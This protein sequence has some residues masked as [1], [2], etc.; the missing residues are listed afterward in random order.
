MKYNRIIQGDCVEVMK[1][2]DAGSVPLIVADPP[3]NQGIEYEG[4]GYSDNLSTFEYDKWT[5]Q[6]LYQANRIIAPNGSIY[7]FINDENAGSVQHSMRFVGVKMRNWIIWY[8]GFGEAQQ[9]KFGR[10]KTHILYSVKDPD[11]FTF[12]AN[13]IRVP[14]D[15]QTKYG[16][17]RAKD[18]GKVPDDVW[19]IS[20]VCGTFKERLPFPCQ[21]PE[22]V[23][24]RI[25][26]ASSNPGDLVFD[27]FSGS[28][29]V[30]SV[31]KQLNRK[32]MGVELSPVY[33]KMSRE[34]L[35]KVD[36]GFNLGV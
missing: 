8:Y 3:Y 25:I 28:G 21:L 34:R 11:N 23:V 16:D 4:S 6:W 14:S 17:G 12:N 10:C 7:V 27:P 15:R 29:T 36:A 31:A 1:T 33:A 32:Y 20:R 26:M 19:K 18:N 13:Q 22:A 9:K 35:E 5:I 24:S 30:C 2:M